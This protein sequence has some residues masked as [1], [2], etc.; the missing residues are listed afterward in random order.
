M[1]RRRKSDYKKPEKTYWHIY[2]LQNLNSEKF[3]KVVNKILKREYI[4]IK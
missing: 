1:P 2:S 3:I 4:L